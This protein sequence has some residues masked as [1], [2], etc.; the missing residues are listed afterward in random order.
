MLGKLTAEPG[1]G[2]E[3]A[4]ILLEA[5]AALDADDDCLLYVVSRP[6][7]D[8]DTVLVSETWRSE[9]A[10]RGSLERDQVRALIA[11]AGPLLAGPPEPIRVRPLGGKGMDAP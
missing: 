11:R 10:H 5:A 8:P 7:D 1:K 4:A 6:Q 2:D 9:E 3:L